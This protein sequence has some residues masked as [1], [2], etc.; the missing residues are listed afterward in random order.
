MKKIILN[1]VDEYTRHLIDHAYHIG[2]VTFAVLVHR[3]SL[4]TSS[5]PLS[6]N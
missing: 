4:A 2:I 1:T 5:T 6:T 3:Q